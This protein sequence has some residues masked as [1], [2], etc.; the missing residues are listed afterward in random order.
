MRES[1]DD[2]CIIFNSQLSQNDVQT[3]GF[4]IEDFCLGCEQK[5]K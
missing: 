2:F 3:A 1:L 5:E 4:D